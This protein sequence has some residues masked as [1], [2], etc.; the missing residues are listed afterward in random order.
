MSQKPTA[1]QYLLTLPKDRVTTYKAL[2]EK[3]D[4]HPRAIASY[5]RTNQEYDKYPCYKVVWN[6]GALTGYILW[7]EEKARRLTEDGVIIQD[8]VVSEEFI[9]RQL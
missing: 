4:T 7:L 1:L 5:M 6:T 2:A 9:I 3:F 8:G